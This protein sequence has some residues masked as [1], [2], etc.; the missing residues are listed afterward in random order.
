M[1]VAEDTG[2]RLGEIF[3]VTGLGGIGIVEDK[4]TTIAQKALLLIDAFKL[5]CSW[6]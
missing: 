2:K 4:E 3:L 5:Q 1:C 6:L